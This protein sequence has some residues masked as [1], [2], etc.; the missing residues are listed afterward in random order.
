MWAMVDGPAEEE[1]AIDAIGRSFHGVIN[2][3]S[4]IIGGAETLR[5][6]GR[7]MTD[8]QRDMVIDMVVEQSVAIQE[9]LGELSRRPPAEL[10]AAI[11]ASA[12]PS[13]ATTGG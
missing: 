12:L 8:A 1:R 11:D 4:V 7:E 3:A 6:S 5:R 10:H 13:P 9:I 2:S